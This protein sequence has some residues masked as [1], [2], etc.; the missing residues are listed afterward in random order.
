[1]TKL[2]AV[3]LKRTSHVLAALTRTDPPQTDEPVDALIGTGLQVRFI[4]QLPLNLTFYARDL[5]AVTVDD[6][7]DV[8][9]N[10]QNYQVVQDPATRAFQ[11][12]GVG[13]QGL[14]VPDITTANGARVTVNTAQSWPAIVVLQ[15]L[16]GA[17]SPPPVIV[18]LLTVPFGP[19]A[20]LPAS[21]VASGDK[22]NMY[23]LVQTLPPFSQTIAVA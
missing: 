5:S 13:P 16:L 2:T 22:W 14:V 12:T 23:A 7:P 15:K 6:Q 21:A 3:Y 8:L 17:G 9:I 20:A 1:M 11:V 4:G 18:P 10:R 19:A